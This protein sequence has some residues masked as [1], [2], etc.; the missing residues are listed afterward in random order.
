[1]LGIVTLSFLAV[2]VVG[3]ATV[4]GVGGVQRIVVYPELLWALGVGGYLMGR[5]TQAP[6]AALP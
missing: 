3:V 5:E 4:I 6:A 2:N 1:M